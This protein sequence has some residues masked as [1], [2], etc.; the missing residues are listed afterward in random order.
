MAEPTD[1]QTQIT[2]LEQLDE[3]RLKITFGDGLTKTFPVRF[4]RLS[5]PCAHCIDEMTGIL[6]LKPSQVP[7]HV[8]P[9]NIEPVGQYAIRIH[10][11][12][13]HNTGI[14]TFKMLRNLSLPKS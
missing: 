4:L 8:H 11:S 1:P 5:C 7:P 14:Y 2:A 13:S 12:D 3:T 9:T 6:L 10:W